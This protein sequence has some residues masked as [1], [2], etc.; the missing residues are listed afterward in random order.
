VET[1]SANYEE[2]TTM[3]S[4]IRKHL[5]KAV[6]V[7][8]A[9]LATCLFGGSANAQSF[10][11]KF[12]LP[13]ETHWGQAVLPA[14]DYQLRFTQNSF[15]TEMLVIQNA[16]SRRIVAFEPVNIR[17]DSTKGE[18]ALLIT[19]RGH[20]RIVHSLRIAE[21]GQAFVYDRALARAAEEARQTQDVPVVVAQK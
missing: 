2:E 20:Q 14:G 3:N 7:A 8:S 12:T 1:Q 21:L 4:N 6:V 16:K 15:G 10:K 11:G 5:L 13:S 17:E 18:S 19:T 9:L